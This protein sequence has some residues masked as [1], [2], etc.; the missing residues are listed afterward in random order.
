MGGHDIF[1]LMHEM[2]KLFVD[3]HF[4]H[5]SPLDSEACFL[6]KKI[7]FVKIRVVNYFYLFFKGKIK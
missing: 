4:S 6:V 3:P 1:V 5:M 7:I 2:Y